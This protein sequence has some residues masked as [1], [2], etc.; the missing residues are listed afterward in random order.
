M[1]L[2]DPLSGASLLVVMPGDYGISGAFAA[3]LEHLG[4]RHRVVRCNEY[5]GRM[6]LG[7]KVAR[8]LHKLAGDRGYRRRFHKRNDMA[9]MWEQIGLDHFDY[10]LC[11]RPDLLPVE[12]LVRL[13]S[14]GRRCFA[15]TWDGLTRYAVTAEQRRCF[16]KLHVFDPLDARPSEGLPLLGNFYFDCYPELL[17][18]ITLPPADAYHIGA[19][20]GRWPVIEKACRELLA[21]GLRPDVRQFLHRGRAHVPFPPYVTKIFDHM[22]YEQ[23]LAESLRCR[24]LLDIHNVGIHQGLSFRAFEAV[25]Y[26]RKLVTTNP[27]VREQDFYR[28]SNIYCLGHDSRTLA[29]FVAEPM[30]ALPDAVRLRYG[31]SAWI[32][33]ALDLPA[34]Q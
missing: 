22:P 27:L 14:R 13:K 5:P 29:D 32:R 2:R 16:E 4:S 1:A 30:E 26:G 24:L 34:L 15:Y 28:P 23:A 3:N 25:G 12:D 18:Q 21:I 9:K 6:S 8:L 20:D 10:V 7:Q 19:H 31:F 11:I 17:P 33:R